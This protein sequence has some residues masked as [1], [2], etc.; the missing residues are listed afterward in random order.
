MAPSS[1]QLGAGLPF[2]PNNPDM[3][4]ETKIDTNLPRP[5]AYHANSSMSSSSSMMQTAIEYDSISDGNLLMP[6]P[7]V[8][9]VGDNKESMLDDIS[10]SAKSVFPHAKSLSVSIS[11]PNLGCEIN[12]FVLD[13]PGSA[14]TLYLDGR[15]DESVSLLEKWLFLPLVC[16]KLADIPLF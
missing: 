4:F 8:S 14:K 5:R 16:Y 3:I 7:V 13:I 15:G 6:S 12:G 1:T 2:I 10:C 9:A 11:G